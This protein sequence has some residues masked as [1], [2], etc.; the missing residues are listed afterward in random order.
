MLGA[1]IIVINMEDLKGE[2]IKAFC[3]YG[4]RQVDIR[5]RKGAREENKANLL[6][7]M[8]I[9]QVALRHH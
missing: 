2:I 8:H 1:T 9:A 4:S 7:Y 5:E 3:S 6:I